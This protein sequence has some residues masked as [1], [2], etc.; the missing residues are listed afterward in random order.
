MP[1]QR[2]ATG[3]ICLIHLRRT[4]LVRTCDRSTQQSVDEIECR[5]QE[6]SPSRLHHS[7]RTLFVTTTYVMQVPGRVLTTAPPPNQKT[8]RLVACRQAGSTCWRGRRVHA[9][10]SRFT[11]DL[12][13]SPTRRISPASY[14]TYTAGVVCVSFQQFTA[15]FHPS[16]TYLG[17]PSSRLRWSPRPSRGGRPRP[18]QKTK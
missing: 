8:T 17:A 18:A 2:V 7:V 9:G 6:K 10:R 3:C 13:P 15:S 12:A 16:L 5:K 11:A 14:P 4:P 1:Q